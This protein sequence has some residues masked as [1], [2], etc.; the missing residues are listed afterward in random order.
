VRV[1]KFLAFEHAPFEENEYDGNKAE[2]RQG[3]TVAR[4]MWKRDVLDGE[5]LTDAD[6]R[7]ERVSNARVVRW[8]DGSTQIVVG[9]ERFDSVSRALKTERLCLQ[10]NPGDGSTSTKMCLLSHAALE[11]EMR[12]RPPSLTSDAHRT[13]TLRAKKASSKQ[14]RVKEI[15]CSMD[16]EREQNEKVKLRDDAIR[17]DAARKRRTKSSRGGGGERGGG[18]RRATAG[19]NRD[20]IE[21][22]APGDY[23]DV[24]DVGAL[25]AKSRAPASRKAI[26]GDDD[27]DDDD[28]D[29]DDDDDDG[30]G[31]E[32][33]A[34][35][36]AASKPK[37]DPSPEPPPKPRVVKPARAPSPSSSEDDFLD[38]APA[39][40]AARADRDSDREPAP[41]PKREG[42]SDDE[43]GPVNP[44]KRRRVIANDS[45]DE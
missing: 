8:S 40:S 26:F 14:A 20:F 41:P 24:G 5:I 4:W 11:E 27:D 29:D 42:A 6:G 22:G 32:W 44:S 23:D 15:Y 45:D 39:V 10:T 30:D 16:P 17:R 31:D 36:R 43:N 19:M 18:D 37:R 13:F 28:S 7:P 34:E 1:P 33:G 35:T 38:V 3:Q 25:K 12:L 2:H 21:E 9:D